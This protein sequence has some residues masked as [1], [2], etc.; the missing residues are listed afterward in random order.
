MLGFLCGKFFSEL[1]YPLK[2]FITKRN[3]C[4]ALRCYNE[5]NIFKAYTRNL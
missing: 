4:I 5:L 2:M 1:F 3:Y